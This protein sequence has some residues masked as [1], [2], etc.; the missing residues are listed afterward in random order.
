MSNLNCF[1]FLTRVKFRETS[2]AETAAILSKSW[3]KLYWVHKMRLVP[4][5]EISWFGL[6]RR[7]EPR[8]LH[9]W[10]SITGVR[11]STAFQL[12]TGRDMMSMQDKRQDKRDR[13]DTDYADW[14]QLFQVQAGR[15]MYSVSSN[16]SCGFVT[17]QSKPLD[18]KIRA[19]VA[20]GILEFLLFVLRFC[21]CLY[22]VYRLYHLYHVPHA[23]PNSQS[24]KPAKN[25]CGIFGSNF[26]KSTTQRFPSFGHTFF[27]GIQ[28]KYVEVIV[29]FILNEIPNDI[30]NLS[31]SLLFQ[32][33][34]FTLI[35]SILESIIHYFISHGVH[36]DVDGQ[37]RSYSLPRSGEGAN[38][39]VHGT[40]MISAIEDRFTYKHDCSF[41][42]LIRSQSIWIQAPSSLIGSL[43][44]RVFIWPYGKTTDVK[45][46]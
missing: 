28:L 29:F 7:F 3:T 32:C 1:V 36:R 38:R 9:H 20:F 13:R 12:E 45:F 15:N 40:I 4:D 30:A 19:T 17:E 44:S 37:G 22:H 39:V 26:A 16:G 25:C 46:A 2:N 34:C 5:S 27:Q 18:S 14:Y 6:R 24:W 35:I 11:F 31:K 42:R 33:C 10:P 21:T 41:R 43:F 8:A 23:M